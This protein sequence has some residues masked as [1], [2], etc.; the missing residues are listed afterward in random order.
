[1]MVRPRLAD[2]PRDTSVGPHE[3]K[4]GGGRFAGAH[5]FSPVLR[6]ARAIVGMQRCGPAVAQRLFGPQPRD[7]APA[8]VHERAPSRWVRAEN[9]DGRNLRQHAKAFFAFA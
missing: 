3:P 9:A 8:T 7:F 5:R 4:F 1:M 2:E 6:H